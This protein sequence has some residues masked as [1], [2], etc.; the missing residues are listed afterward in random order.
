MTTPLPY[1]HQWIE[2]DDVGAVVETLQGDWIT[3]GPRVAEFEARVAE[4]CGARFAV[5]VNSGTAA[6]HAAVFA[7]GLGPGDEVITTPLSFPAS[8][9]CALYQGAT[10]RFAD[11]EPDGFNLDP[12]AVAAR[13]TSRT[14]AVIPVDY[15]GHPAE[16]DEIRV[17]ARRNDSIVI[18]DAAHS[19]GAEYRGRRVGALS[20]LTVFSFHPVKLITTAEGGMVLT[21][22]ADLYERLM[23][24]RTHGIVRD[25]RASEIGPWFY[26]MVDLGFNYRLSDLHSA[27]GL[28][29]LR[30]VD[31]FLARRRAIAA[32]YDVAFSNIPA[33]RPIVPR[34]HVRPA[35]HLYVVQVDFDRLGMSRGRL[36]AELAARGVG[37]Q[38]HYIPIHLHPFYRAR[39]GHKPGDFPHAEA[40]YERALSVPLYPKMADADVERVIAGVQDVVGRGA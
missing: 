27:L 13:I 8:A 9:N 26:E 10:P 14:R 16:L 2:A 17:I 37:S 7:A 30:K 23:R 31:R 32:R 35:Y 25:A 34:R 38:V 5:A 21:D 3:Q 33:L 24:F 39:F 1:S 40:F 12:A 19:L 28:S 36:V 6:L 18:E 20:D 15:A 11:V 4:Y 29:Q 22:R